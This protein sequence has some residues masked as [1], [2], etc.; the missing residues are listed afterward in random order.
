MSLPLIWGRKQIQFPKRR[1]FF[2]FLE[3]QTIDKV[4]KSSNP[5]W[6]FLFLQFVLL[7][8]SLF[9]FLLD[10]LFLFSLIFFLYTLFV[11]LYFI[12]FLLSL[13]FCVRLYFFLIYYVIF[14]FISSRRKQTF[15]FEEYSY[16]YFPAALRCRDRNIEAH[17]N[18]KF[19][20]YVI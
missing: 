14:L 8:F 20:S 2:V 12:F 4:Q 9:L 5:E 17:V 3:Y 10:P 1:V 7:S 16:S 6:T 13:R 15:S 18:W 19:N 11:Y